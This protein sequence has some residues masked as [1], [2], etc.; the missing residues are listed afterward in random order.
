MMNFTNDDIDNLALVTW[1]EARGEGP[2]GCSAVMN[3]ILNRVGAPGFA[4]TIHDVIFGKNQFTSMS[5][6]SDPEFNLAPESDDL[7][8]KACLSMA[9]NFLTERISSNLAASDITHGAYFYANLK[10]ATSGWFKNHIIDD[11]VNHPVTATIGH[12]TFFK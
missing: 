6:S 11:T 10:T 5:V 7:I 9:K 8:Y 1:K 4:H 12:H 3:V 2:V